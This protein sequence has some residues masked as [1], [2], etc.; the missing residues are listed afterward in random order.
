MID[1]VVQR[2]GSEGPWY[3]SDPE[4]KYK[5]VEHSDGSWFCERNDKTIQ[6]PKRRYI[7]T[8]AVKDHTGVLVGPSLFTHN[9]FSL[10]LFFLSFSH[11]HKTYYSYINN[12]INMFCQCVVTH[13]VYNKLINIKSF[14]VT[15]N[16]C[17]YRFSFCVSL[18]C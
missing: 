15:L 1:H 12:D 13:A 14:Y 5:C 18:R 6:N 9:H 16:T 11:T 3:V 8:V 7:M 17:V 2:E 10:T 4:T